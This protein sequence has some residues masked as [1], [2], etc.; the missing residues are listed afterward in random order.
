MAYLA[1]K[2]MRK[3]PTFWKKKYKRKKFLA[4]CET[5]RTGKQKKKKIMRVIRRT[6]RVNR[7]KNCKHKKKQSLNSL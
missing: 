7:G 4:N 1:H 5:R 3:N 2:K 6:E